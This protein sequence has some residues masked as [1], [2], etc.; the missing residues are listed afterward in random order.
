MSEGRTAAGVSYEHERL[1]AAERR[2]WSDIWDSVPAAVAA[3]RGLELRRFGPVQASLLADLPEVSMLNLVL[4]ATAPGAAAGGHLAAALELTRE[5]GVTPYVQVTPGEPETAAAESALTAAGF[6]P[7]YPWAKF[8][9]DPHPPRFKPPA[10]VEVVEIGAETSE[11]FAA[12]VATGFGLPQWA[13]SLFAGLPGREGW[14]CYVAR[15]DGEIGACGAMLLDGEL[16]VFGPS[17][18]L[19]SARRRGCQLA[20]LRQR[21][22]HA[23][24][25]GC[26]LLFVETGARTPDRPAASYRNILRAGFEEAYVCPNWQ[27]SPSPIGV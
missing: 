3:E 23:A 13:A 18:T 2:Y 19:E 11:P 27:P 5:R 15:V 10:G 16:A 20:L 9:R 17:A 4:G 21:I 14:R 24:A 6:A 12:I 25:A 1:D 22:L 7:G 26:E 8:V